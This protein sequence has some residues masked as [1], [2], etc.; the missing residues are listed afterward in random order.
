[1]NDAT[2]M[3]A[4]HGRMLARFAELALSLAERLHEDAMAAETPHERAELAAA[5]HRICRSGRQSMALEAKLVR[6][7]GR[8]VRAEAAAAEKAQEA[9]IAQRKARVTRAVEQLIWTEVEDDEQLECLEALETRMAAETAA[10]DFLEEPA[11]AQIVRICRAL[12]LPLPPPLAGESVGPPSGTDEGLQ[13]CLQP[14][15]S[16]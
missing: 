13:A 10:D 1:M 11:S 7:A 14:H 9:R 6:D 5:F 8:E 16:G 4:R 2:G 12:N 15:N 3:E